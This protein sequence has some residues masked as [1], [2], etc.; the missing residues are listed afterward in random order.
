MTSQL[1]DYAFTVHLDAT[2]EDA[3]GSTVPV[4]LA[5]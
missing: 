1:D 5:V 2:F 3:L 4:A